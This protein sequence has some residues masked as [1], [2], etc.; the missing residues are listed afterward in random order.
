MTREEIIEL[1]QKIKYD[2]EG[3]STN[4]QYYCTVDKGW[5]AVSEDL[6]GTLYDI[7]E[8]E[9]YRI[10]PEPQ[11]KPFTAENF[12]LFIN[13]P[14]IHIQDCSEIK[15]AK[16]LNNKYYVTGFNDSCVH[17]FNE[18]SYFTYEDFLNECMFWETGDILTPCGVQV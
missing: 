17:V 15:I 2:G 18:Y 9:E 1:L 6:A 8:G 11:Y 13:K 4:L 10:K 16:N 5:N 14:F 3:Y 12:E 7:S